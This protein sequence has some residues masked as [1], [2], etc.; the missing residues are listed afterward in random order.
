MPIYPGYQQGGP[1]IS[2]RE[3]WSP[4]GSPNSR[5]TSPPRGQAGESSGGGWTGDGPWMGATSSAA[6]PAASAAAAIGSNLMSMFVSVAPASAPA[7]PPPVNVVLPPAV[8]AAPPAAA[9]PSQSD[10]AG[11]AEASVPLVAADAAVEQA[12]VAAMSSH[13]SENLAEEMAIKQRVSEDRFMAAGTVPPPVPLYVPYA[14]A[15]KRRQCLLLALVVALVVAFLARDAIGAV[16]VDVV[17]PDPPAPPRPPPP[18]P[19]HPAPPRKSPP[20]A[21][22]PLACDVAPVY[23]SAQHE[24]TLCSCPGVLRDLYEAGRS[25]LKDF[26]SCDVETQRFMRFSKVS[27]AACTPCVQHGKECLRCGLPW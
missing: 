1:Q 5:A 25:E 14:E 13:R 23:A 7:K 12:V 9:E 21:P 4:T 20:P 2:Q 27:P 18:S 10:A 8:L 6:A 17:T 19:P 22:P 11:A 15:S 16:V 3:R 24:M 26:R